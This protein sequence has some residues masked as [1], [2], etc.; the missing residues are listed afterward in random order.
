MLN[1]KNGEI[2]INIWQQIYK[3]QVE[4]KSLTEEIKV[5]E[6]NDSV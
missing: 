5:L 1:K 4:N 2:D 6:K 3:L